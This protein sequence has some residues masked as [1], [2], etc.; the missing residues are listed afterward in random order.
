M[1]NLKKTLTETLKMLHEVYGHFS[2]FWTRVS[3]WHRKFVEGM[4]DAK[5]DPKSGK[6]CTSKTDANI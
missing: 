6:P 1:L 3:K 5:N 4:E 2:M